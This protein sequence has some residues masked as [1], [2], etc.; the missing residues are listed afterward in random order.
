MPIKDKCKKSYLSKTYAK[1]VI[2]K[3]AKENKNKINNATFK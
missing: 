1:A 3:K 2:S